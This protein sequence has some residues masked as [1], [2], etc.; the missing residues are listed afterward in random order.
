MEA[1]ELSTDL[2]MARQEERHESPPTPRSSL[3]FRPPSVSAVI[4]LMLSLVMPVLLQKPMLN[5]DGDL[6][7]HLNH[8]RY[9]LA[10]GHV[11]RTDPFSFTRPGAPF[12]GFEYGSQLVYAFANRV[13][14]LPAVAVLAGL[15]IALTYALLLRF[16]VRRGVDLLLACL[17]VALAVVIGVDHWTAR[18]HLFSFVATVALLSLLEYSGKG[19]LV[20][21]ALLFALWANV[22]GGFVYGW[23][24]IALYLAGSLGE[25]WWGDDPAVWRAR[26]R[27]YSAM[28]ALAIVITVLNPYG[29]SLQRHL[30]EFFGQPFLRDNTAEFVSP[31]FH[32]PEAKF[33]LLV[34]LLVFSGLILN[35]SRPPLPRLLIILSGTVFALDA[36]RNIPLFGLTALP[37]FALHI[38]QGWRR[39]PDPIGIRERFAKTGSKTSTVPWA[40]PVVVFLVFLALNRGR[41]GSRQLVRDEFDA[42]VF[43][44]NAITKA[45][46]AGLEGRIFTPLTWAGYLE[47]AWPEQKIYIDGGTDFFG[48]T[49][50]REYARIRQMSPGWRNILEQRDISLMLLQRETTISH[51]LARDDTW[52]IWYCDSLAVLFRRSPVPPGLAP[53]S[54]ERRLQACV[55]R[56]SSALDDGQQRQSPGQRA[57]AQNT[58]LDRKKGGEGTV[59]ESRSRTGVRAASLGAV[60][61]AAD[62]AVH[63]DRRKEQHVPVGEPADRQP[64]SLQ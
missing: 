35:R 58:S 39:V 61:Q 54:A 16:L 14:G 52:Q 53:D 15:L 49:L 64:V 29:L 40:L 6:A 46:A 25:Q 57:L 28:L 19:A 56:E 42:T 13:G 63:T 10:H 33:F 23:V 44:V 60:V 62:D 24:L 3:E 38:D 4:F 9:M 8:G 17:I 27:R 48:E 45:R 51:E 30:L 36:V 18:P 41:V 59:H 11:I 34:L 7:R 37:L 43:P 47:Y 21:C 26:S 50:F 5:S 20:G 1:R 32:E 22:H 12:V 31:N 2:A 55:R